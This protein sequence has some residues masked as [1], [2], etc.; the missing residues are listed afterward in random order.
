MAKV[1]TKWVRDTEVCVEH[2]ISINYCKTCAALM[3]KKPSINDRILTVLNDQRWHTQKEIAEKADLMEGDSYID[4]GRDIRNL[5]M[6]DSGS[7]PIDERRSDDDKTIHE[8]RYLPPDEAPAFWA[9]RE[10]R[11]AKNKGVTPDVAQ[12]REENIS[13]RENNEFLEK[14]IVELEKELADLR[15]RKEMQKV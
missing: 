1:K 10:A 11:I 13:L 8:Y 3:V 7:H 6:E 15:G 4:I 5:R 12:L 2:G 14:Y 9:K